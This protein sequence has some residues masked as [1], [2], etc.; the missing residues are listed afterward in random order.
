[1]IARKALT[2]MM[3]L[4]L[5]LMCL[6]FVLAAD[7]PKP[8]VPSIVPPAAPPFPT[9][10]AP[11]PSFP[12]M[13]MT[14]A[15]VPAA[16]AKQGKQIAPS[17]PN[18]KP[19]EKQV[20]I[21]VTCVEMGT[22]FVSEIGLT[23]DRPKNKENSSLLVTCLNRRE[24]KMLEALIRAKPGEIDILSKPQLAIP[25]G[26]KGYIEAMAL[27]PGAGGTPVPL[28]P[29]SQDVK[30]VPPPPPA[31]FA[32]VGLSLIVTAAVSKD[33]SYVQLKLEPQRARMVDL[34]TASENIPV[35]ARAET[36]DKRQSVQIAGTQG[37]ESNQVTVFETV[38]L[39][40]SVVIPNG[41]TVV[42]GQKVESNTTI[43]KKKLETGITVTERGTA[44]NM[45]LWV[46]TANVIVGK[47]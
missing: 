38:Q 30:A 3:A 26:G 43:E 24:S 20:Q 46:I 41:G 27:V 45:F 8:M 28:I 32:N 37:V 18:L 31:R 36:P 5:G 34:N 15:A 17:A 22:D 10:V 25:D 11:N 40:T 6:G 39:M 44:N 33:N 13:P 42:I 7:E 9:P 1:M 12:I 35:P 14:P 4:T 29:N 47:P 21:S 16:M 19:G 23:A 2:A